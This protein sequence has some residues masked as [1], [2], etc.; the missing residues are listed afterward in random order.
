MEQDPHVHRD[1]VSF[2]PGVVKNENA[3]V[4]SLISK[5]DIQV[6]QMDEMMETLFLKLANLSI[7]TSGLVLAVLFTRLVFSKAPKW[8]FCLL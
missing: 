7:T 8:L 6:A 3:T 5:V 2:R 4:T 1:P